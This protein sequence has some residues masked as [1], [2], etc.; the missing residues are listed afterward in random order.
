M[1]FLN[2]FFAILLI[3]IAAG[4]AAA[5]DC[6]CTTEGG[7]LT[8]QPGIIAQFPEDLFRVTKMSFLVQI[9]FVCTLLFN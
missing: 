6:P 4:L 5:A 9:F 2:F 3:Q 7:T 8:C 1:R